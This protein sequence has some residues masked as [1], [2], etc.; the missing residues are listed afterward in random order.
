LFRTAAV[1]CAKKFSARVEGNPMR[2]LWLTLELTLPEFE[3]SVWF[4]DVDSFKDLPRE[5]Q[6]FIGEECPLQEQDLICPRTRPEARL[7]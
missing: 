2:D 7:R 4:Y 1:K 3:E 5:L 6:I